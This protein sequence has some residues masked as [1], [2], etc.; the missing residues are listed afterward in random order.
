MSLIEALACEF[1]REVF[2][3]T[4]VWAHAVS[5]PM[6]CA[7]IDAEVPRARYKSGELN[8][9]AIR[10]ALRRLDSLY[11]HHVTRHDYWSFR[12]RKG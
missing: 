11:V 9:R 3:A 6:L 2:D 8:T 12:I 7:A 10:L 4:D 1:G 5:N